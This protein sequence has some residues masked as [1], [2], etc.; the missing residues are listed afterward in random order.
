MLAVPWVVRTVWEQKRVKNM[1]WH[2]RKTWWRRVEIWSSSRNQKENK[3]L[4]ITFHLFCV[5]SPG[6]DLATC[7]IWRMKLRRINTQLFC[8]PA[9]LI[10]EH[11][12]MREK[13]WEQ[14]R[15]QFFFS[16]PT[17]CY[18]ETQWGYLK[19]LITA[20]ADYVSAQEWSVI[21]E[22]ILSIALCGEL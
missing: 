13:S 7:L 19:C 22:K 5:S 12:A 17:H 6:V 3:D 18:Q 21:K 9:L 15:L 2:C 1:W 11:I 4:N 10:C 20:S 14:L 16:S 8:F